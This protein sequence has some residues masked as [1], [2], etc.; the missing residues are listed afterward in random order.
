MHKVLIVED[1]PI[2][3]ME[4][5]DAL[6]DFGYDVPVP[7]E[8][9]DDVVST[10]LSKKPDI[11]IMDINL[12]SFIDGIDAAN[13]INML[14]KIPIVFITAYDNPGIE[15]R[16]L[17]ANPVAILKKPITNRELENCIKSVLPA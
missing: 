5:R 13:R 17:K 16:A 9:G 10:V 15:A 12:R 8:S 7:V 14:G 4:L 6:I 3:G 2:I 1:E 11:I